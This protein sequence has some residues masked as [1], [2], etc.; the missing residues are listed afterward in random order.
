MENCIVQIRWSTLAA[1]FDALSGKF[2]SNVTRQMR[3]LLGAGNV[4]W[5]SSSDERAMPP[6]VAATFR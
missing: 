6:G 4:E 3:H 5:L 2:R 1:Y